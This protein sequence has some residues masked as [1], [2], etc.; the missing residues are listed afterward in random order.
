M[1]GITLG[2][3]RVLRSALRDR[4]SNLDRN[5][6]DPAYD[7]DGWVTREYDLVAGLDA[8]LAAFLDA[9]N[10]ARGAAGLS[11]DDLA[12]AGY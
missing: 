8:E 10:A 2:E 5:Y 4:K 1:E 9:A 12:L 3:A 7:R 6:S 11:D